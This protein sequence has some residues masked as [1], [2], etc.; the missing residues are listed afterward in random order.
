MLIASNMT[1]EIEIAS[2]P[3]LPG[4]VNTIAVEGIKS[5]LHEANRQSAL[6]QLPQVKQ[7]D[8]DSYAKFELLFDPQTSGGLLAGISADKVAACLA[9]L[10]Q[11]GYAA[12]VIGKVTSGSP[13][14]LLSA[15]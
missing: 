2:I 9:A 13:M 1:A 3:V 7:D 10:K 5:T 4:A 6:L 8:L 11:A 15:H 12:A 14:I